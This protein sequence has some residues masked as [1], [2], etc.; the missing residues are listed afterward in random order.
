MRGAA[1]RPVGV[2]SSMHV[3]QQVEAAVDV[4]D[5]VQDQ[6]AWGGRV[7]SWRQL[8]I[9]Q[10]SRIHGCSKRIRDHAPR[11]LDVLQTARARRDSPDPI[12]P[13]LETLR[14]WPSAM[15]CPQ[16]GQ[17]DVNL[18]ALAAWAGLAPPLRYP[19]SC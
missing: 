13:G 10:A 3:T 7:L 1:P 14:P 5:Q 16:G 6:P 8:V 12:A 9:G 11:T 18:E 15:L 2:D 17:P 4:A 19:L